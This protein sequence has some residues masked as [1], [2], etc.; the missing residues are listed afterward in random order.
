M[1]DSTIQPTG[2]VTAYDA[3]MRGTAGGSQAS[4]SLSGSRAVAPIQDSTQDNAS[5]VRVTLS[6]DGLQALR[7][8]GAN[9]ASNANSDI[10]D[11]GLPDT[12]K[13]LLKRI[14]ELRAQLQ[15]KALEM[16]RVMADQNLSEEQRKQATDRLQTEIASLNAA[17]TQASQQL[18]E[19]MNDSKLDST[20]RMK[21]ASLIMK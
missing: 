18:L 7:T 4:D 1:L 9:Q 5:S 11:S 2:A 19:A 8:G 6:N 20:Q 21:A 10:D 15:E 13:E 16:Q 3:G 12:V 17:L 14:R